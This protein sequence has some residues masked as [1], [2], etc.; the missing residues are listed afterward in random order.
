MTASFDQ[1][2]QTELL[3]RLMSGSARPELLCHYTTQSG[4]LGILETRSLWATD[5][6]FLNDSAEFQYALSMAETRLDALF[7]RIADSWADTLIARWRRALLVAPRTRVFVASFSAVDDDLS[8]WRAYARTN[9]YIVS[10]SYDQLLTAAQN[11]PMP[12]IVLSCVYDA[13]E[14]ALLMDYALDY[15][16]AKYRTE[17]G[18]ERNEDALF[19]FEVHFF[20]HLVLLAACFKHPSFSAEREWRLIVRE[21]APEDSAKFVRLRTGRS[22]LVPYLSIPLASD[23]KVVSLKGVRIG[24]TPHPLLAE[25]AVKDALR[26]HR[27]VAKSVLR[28]ETPFREW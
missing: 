5:I 22:T 9:G 26:Q 15:L 23:D 16:T 1:T 2:P 25:A 6:R 24:P 10:L 27:A 17:A 13:A 12:G 11:A 21:T 8:Q 28:S 7:E 14:Q 18:G 3:A 20:A 4:L 19:A